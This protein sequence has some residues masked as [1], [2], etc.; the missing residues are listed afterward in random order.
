LRHFHD[1]AVF[2]SPVA[3]RIGFAANGEIRGKDALRAYWNAALAK[4]PNLHFM[5]TAI[6]EGTDTIV[7]AFKTQSGQDRAEVLVF[8]RGLVTSGR[9]TFG[10]CE[11][12]TAE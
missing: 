5:V 10:C 1:H 4:N 11:S 3:Q 9:G 6:Y 12:P 2:V 8:D 7:I